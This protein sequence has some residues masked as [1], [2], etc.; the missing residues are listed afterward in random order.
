ME[1]IRNHAIELANV[2]VSESRSRVVAA[3]TQIASALSD[4]IVIWENNTGSQLP[5]ADP[6]R[7]ALRAHDTMLSIDAALIA[8]EY[9]S[10]FPDGAGPFG[11]TADALAEI[12][13]LLPLVPEDWRDSPTYRSAL[14]DSL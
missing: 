13:E 6:A 11:S 12:R 3:A 8:Y 10:G 14:F 1:T 2:W 4:A 5:D 7:T 9:R